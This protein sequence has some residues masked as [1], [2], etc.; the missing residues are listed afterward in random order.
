MINLCGRRRR[1]S[2]SGAGGLLSAIAM[3]QASGFLFNGGLAEF[4][5]LAAQA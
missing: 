4:D 1:H 5:K 2:P 3:T